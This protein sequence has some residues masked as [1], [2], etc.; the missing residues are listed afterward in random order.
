M[1]WFNLDIKGLIKLSDLPE[2][3]TTIG[4]AFLPSGHQH[5]LL[6]GG[7]GSKG[8]VARAIYGSTE[9]DPVALGW[10]RK[11]LAYNAVTDAWC[12]Y[13][14]IAEDDVPRCGAAAGLKPGKTPESYTLLIAGGEK[15]P[16][17][18][19]N[20]VSVA[21][22]RKMGKFGATAWG[23]V[24]VY[25]LMMVGM[26]CIFIF[27]KKDENDYFRGGNRIPWYVAG[28]SIFATMLSSITFIAIPTQAYLQDWR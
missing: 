10:Q 8:W 21:S 4:A 27:K 24:G 14:E 11:I 19:T 23:V 17:L 12:E 16:A 6:V 15:A 28:M 3:M 18:R 22:F 20:T 7:F 13:G 9:T 2:G 5:I 26:A 1:V 25:A